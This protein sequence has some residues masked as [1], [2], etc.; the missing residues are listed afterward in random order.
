MR[1]W[2]IDHADGLLLAIG[3][4]LM[5]ITLL[6]L[7]GCQPA[8]PPQLSQVGNGIAAA[9]AYRDIA[10]RSADAPAVVRGALGEEGQ[11]RSLAEA[12][13]A[14]VQAEK[15]AATTTERVIRL[16]DELGAERRQWLGDRLKAYLWWIV[17]SAVAL[18]VGMGLLGTFLSI[19][20]GGLSVWAGWIFKLIPLG[21]IFSG[22]ARR[23]QP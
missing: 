14:L 5:A 15:Q 16:E 13:A 20:T 12:S 4:T 10:F 3:A 11:K 21:G 9:E 8:K 18:W 7:A 23:V 6:M 2:L 17:G 19:G 22:L 1:D